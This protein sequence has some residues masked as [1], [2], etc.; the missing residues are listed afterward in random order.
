MYLFI[1]SAFLDT[2]SEEGEMELFRRFFHE[3]KVIYSFM[4]LVD[5]FPSY[6]FILYLALCLVASFLVGLE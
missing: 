6:R 2:D 4:N 5:G 3:F 1:F